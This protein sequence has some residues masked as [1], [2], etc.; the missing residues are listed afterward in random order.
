MPGSDEKE[1]KDDGSDTDEDSYN[2]LAIK[3]RRDRVR[4]R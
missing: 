1:D 2:D 4:F 3:G